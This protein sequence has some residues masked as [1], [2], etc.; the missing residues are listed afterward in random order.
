MRFEN[1]TVSD[2]AV[3]KIVQ[4]FRDRSARNKRNRDGRNSADFARDLHEATP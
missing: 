3:D 4:D 2:D 1:G